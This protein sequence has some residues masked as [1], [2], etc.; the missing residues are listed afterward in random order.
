MAGMAS[1]IRLLRPLNCVMVGFA[2]LIGEVAIYKTVFAIP[3]L[4]G[5]ITGFSIT[6]ASMVSN[7]YWDRAVDKIN[8]PERPIPS[9]KVK[10]IEAAIFTTLLSAVGLVA[11]FL[12]N[13]PAS[14]LIAS[15]GLVMFFLYNYRIKQSGLPGNMLVSASIALPLIYGGLIYP[16]SSNA[17]LDP[18]RLL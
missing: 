15:A 12:T 11:A 16:Q 9:G 8:N 17:E 2:V 18:S 1:L 5:F 7:D 3:T 6:G 13:F 10:P 14:F 4:L